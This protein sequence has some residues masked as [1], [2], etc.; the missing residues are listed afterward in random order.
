MRKIKILDD[1]NLKED[2]HKHL[3]SNHKDFF[4]DQV[5][6]EI[7]SEKTKI[8]ETISTVNF[9]IFGSTYQGKGTRDG[10]DFK[11]ASHVVQNII[12]ENGEFYGMVKI[13]DTPMGR[14][15][16]NFEEGE[17]KLIPI[18]NSEGEISS[19]DIDTNH[20][21]SFIQGTESFHYTVK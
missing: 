2:I 4:R 1:G 5:I 12:L 20:S 6:N 15:L 14:P 3:I 18:Y 11:Y 10:V 16:N 17:Y 19:F 13:L 21:I 7:L 9:N 8:E